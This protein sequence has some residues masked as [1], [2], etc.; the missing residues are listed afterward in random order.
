MRPSREPVN[1]GGSCRHLVFLGGP[2]QHDLQFIIRLWAVAAPSPRPIVRASRHH[3]SCWYAGYAANNEDAGLWSRAIQRRRH[4]L[5]AA[6]PAG[7]PGG[8]CL[9]F[10]LSQY[11]VWYG[12]PDVFQTSTIAMIVST[13]SIVNP[14][15]IALL[16]E[17]CGPARKKAAAPG[18]KRRP[19]V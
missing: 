18:R 2:A 6:S 3:R 8:F 11:S 19:K 17:A 16:R 7:S 12:F 13:A 14:T 15:I 5:T 9:S 1:G 4:R 10:E